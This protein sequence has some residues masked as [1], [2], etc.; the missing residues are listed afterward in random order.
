MVNLDCEKL[1]RNVYDDISTRYQ[2]ARGS[3]LS[4]GL[5]NVARLEKGVLNVDYFGYNF[6]IKFKD[7]NGGYFEID[8]S[9]PSKG[10]EEIVGYVKSQVETGQVFSESGFLS[11]IGKRREFRKYPKRFEFAE[12][13]EKIGEDDSG[14][15]IPVLHVLYKVDKKRLAKLNSSSFRETASDYVVKP[16]LSWVWVHRKK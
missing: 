10:I 2:L 14:R 8:I 12:A 6:R 13:T 3:D 7:N 1:I 11:S 5:R 9:S 4:L 15:K 16:I